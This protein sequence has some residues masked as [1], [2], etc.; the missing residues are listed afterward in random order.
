MYHAP[1]SAD[2]QPEGVRT[3]ISEEDIAQAV[4]NEQLRAA[5]LRKAQAEARALFAPYLAVAG[6]VTALLVALVLF[7]RV[8]NVLIGGWVVVVGGVN[9]LAWRKAVD[10]DAYSSSN[11][12]N[13][14]NWFPVAEAFGLAAIWSSLPTYG[15]TVADPQGTPCSAACSVR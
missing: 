13:S 11:L 3:E 9:W 15:F 8:S 4:G 10:Q 7:G 2:Q 5:H 12:R 1:V 14:S 6:T